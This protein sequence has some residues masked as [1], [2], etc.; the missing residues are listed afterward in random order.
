MDTLL[1]AD[2][3]PATGLFGRRRFGDEVDRA[4]H[5]GGGALLVL[6]VQPTDL[7]PPVAHRLREDCGEGPVFG[8]TGPGEIGILLRGTAMGDARRIAERLVATVRETAFPADAT[9]WGGLVRCPAGGGVEGHDLLIDAAE[10]WRRARASDV[11]VVT[12]FEP[13]PVVTRRL[14]CRGWI[15]GIV[16]DGRLTLHAQPIRETATGRVDRYELLLRVRDELTGCPQPPGALLD[17]AERADAV[18]RI[19]LWAVARAVR[20]LEAFPQG[21]CLQVNV[22]GRSFGDP[23]LLA[24]VTH[25]LDRSGVRPD[26]L[27]LELTEIALIGNFTE[28][29]RTAGRLRRLGCGLALD[30][31]GAGYGSFRYLKYLPVDQ[32][33]I[34]G[35]FVVGLGHSRA[36]RAMVEA[37]VSVCRALGVRAVAESVED[38]ATLRVVEELGVDYCQGY[39]IGRP[40]PAVEVLGGGGV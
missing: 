40:R 30:D 12:R 34:D 26:R 11:P 14:A 3:D 39:L 4:L 25:L 17:T 35:D 2:R 38:P 29:C 6:R 8:L 31:F 24:A 32:V 9:A 7:I 28:A 23:R 22:S 20:L 33:K 19:D 18:L 37:V 27:V 10:G 1:P 13:A 15:D 16:H 5:D 21:P 36:D